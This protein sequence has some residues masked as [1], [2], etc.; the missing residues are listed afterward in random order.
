MT[1]LFSILLASD[2]R[3]LRMEMSPI[4][5]EGGAE[6]KFWIL[7]RSMTCISSSIQSYILIPILE[8]C[9]KAEDLTLFQ[10]LENIINAEDD[11]YLL[12]LTGLFL[13]SE[14]IPLLMSQPGS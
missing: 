1:G 8:T 11:I 10:Q 5:S 14:L 12:K 3:D 9:H 4:I 13:P 7:L 6:F 2:I